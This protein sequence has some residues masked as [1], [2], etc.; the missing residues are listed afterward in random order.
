VIVFHGSYLT[1]EKIDLAKSKPRKDFGQGFYVTKFRSQAELWAMRIG[2]DHNTDG[3]ITTFDF[4]ESAYEDEELHSIR[5]DGYT[6][7]W[8]DFVMSNRSKKT[9]EPYQYDLI[10]GPVAN[11]A[12]TIRIFDYLRG[13]ISKKDF[14]QE[15]HFKQPSHQICF[16]TVKS[17]QMLEFINDLTEIKIIHINDFIIKALITERGLKDIEAT[18]KYFTSQ[19]YKQLIDKSTDLYKKPWQEIYQILLSEF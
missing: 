11:D 16:C 2:E 9:H 18:E 6:E 12:V 5:F 7:E 1:I 13:D 10:E 17:L 4:D 19:T 8:F 15:L 3:V 14:L